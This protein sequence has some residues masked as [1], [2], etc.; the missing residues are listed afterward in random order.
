MHVHMQQG[1]SIDVIDGCGGVAGA[2]VAVRGAAHW[3]HRLD[4]GV[5]AVNGWAP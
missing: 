5:A 3:P 4:V 2:E 1:R